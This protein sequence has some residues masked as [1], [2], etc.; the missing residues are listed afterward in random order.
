MFGEVSDRRSKRMFVEKGET[1]VV[2]VEEGGKTV[3]NRYENE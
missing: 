3:W 1:G 2:D